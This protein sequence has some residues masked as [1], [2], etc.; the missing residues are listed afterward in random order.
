MDD[1]SPLFSFPSCYSASSSIAVSS[2]LFLSPSS[3][4]S[5][6]AESSSVLRRAASLATTR[7]PSLYKIVS[8]EQE[9]KDDPPKAKTESRE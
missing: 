1:S 5:I 7:F 2:A 9:R 4:L 3:F 8:L 6:S